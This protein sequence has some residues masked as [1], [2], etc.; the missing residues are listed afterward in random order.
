MKFCI[1]Y[2]SAFLLLIACDS[3]C[4]K[5]EGMISS[6]KFQII[7][8]RFDEDLVFD[9]FP[10]DQYIDSIRYVKLELTDESMIGDISSLEVYKDRIYILDEQTLSLFLFA[11][12]GK[13]ISKICNIGQG[14]GEYISLDY[15]S[16]DKEN[17]H[18]VLTDLMG[19]WVM[20]YD[21]SGNFIKRQK[22]PFWIDGIYALKNKGYALFA[23]KRNNKQY[24]DQEYSLY[25]V[26]SLMEIKNVYFSYNSNNYQG[27][28]ALVSSNGGFSSNNDQDY[29][30]SLYRDTVYEI[31]QDQL[32]VKYVFDFG[33]YTFDNEMVIRDN[34]NFR[35]YFNQRNY[36]G[37]VKFQVNEDVVSFQAVILNTP[38]TWMSFY[39]QKT[40]NLLNRP[41]Y[42]LGSKSFWID[43]KN[44]YDSYFITVWPNDYFQKFKTAP[45]NKTV[46]SSQM[47][48]ILS[49][50][51]E[52]DNPILVFYKLKNF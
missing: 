29:F 8:P 50:Y 24:F 49:D 35:S 19:Y 39:N 12:D 1:L 17:N 22:I 2:I 37:L 47:E 18:L 43:N 36:A 7:T 15:F 44:V 41:A 26:D 14:P 16:I 11:L 21:L 9:P 20:R 23:N 31:K 28:R 42:S 5:K 13:F 6:G 48:K 34:L 46:G 38:F 25:I 33:E 32:E 51:T 27:L 52:D 3:T 40:G 30:Y 10:L 4:R 45:M